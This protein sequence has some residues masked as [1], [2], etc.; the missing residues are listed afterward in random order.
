MKRTQ[1][2]KTEEGWAKLRYEEGKTHS[3]NCGNYDGG[4]K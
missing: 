1:M 4:D 3:G 2:Y